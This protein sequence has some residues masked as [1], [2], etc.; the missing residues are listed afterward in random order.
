MN[1]N[2]PALPS[3]SD[4]H[5]LKLTPST[6]AQ[7][8]IFLIEETH[9]QANCWLSFSLEINGQLDVDKLSQALGH[10]GQQVPLLQTRLLYQDGVLWQQRTID[11][12]VTLELTDLRHHAAPEA[13]CQQQVAQNAPDN[14]CT[15]GAL[16]RFRLW[17]LGDE[18]YC[19][20][21]WFHHSLLDVRSWTILN[22]LLADS[23]NALLSGS[24]LPTFPWLNASSLAD[25]EQTW[26]TASTS[27]D[28][29]AFWQEYV[30]RLPAAAMTQ[31]II[32]EERRSLNVRHILHLQEEKRARILSLA[33]QQE[34]KEPVIYL[35]AVA[36][37]MRHLTG[38]ETV[39]LSLPVKGTWNAD[40]PGMTSNVVPLILDLPA[41]ATLQQ[42]LAMV[43]QELRLVLPHQRYRA[44]AI[45]RHAGL[46]ARQGF[47]PHV[48]IM[49]F[50]QGASFQNCQ[51]QAHFGRH[52]DSSDMHFTFWGDSRQGEVDILLDDAIEGHRPGELD[53]IGSQLR[54]FLEQLT[55]AADMPLY[56]LDELAGLHAHPQLAQSFYA[57][58][59]RPADAGVLRWDRPVNQ[60]ISQFYAGQWV[61]AGNSPLPVSKIWLDNTLVSFRKIDPLAKPD[62]AAPGTLLAVDSLGW[63]IAVAD[64]AV[65]IQGF[66]SLDGTPC[67]P[68]ALA[69]AS[70]ISPGSVLKIIS[71]NEARQLTQQWHSSVA[72]QGW[73]IERLK[74]RDGSW[75]SAARP[76]QPHIQPHWQTTEWAAVDTAREDALPALL[77]AWLIYIARDTGQTSPQIGVRLSSKAYPAPGALFASTLPFTVPV[78]LSLPFSHIA[79]TVGEEYSALLSHLPCPA[80][81]LQSNGENASAFTLCVVENAGMVDTDDSPGHLLTL[82]YNSQLNAI[83]W[84]YN[85]SFLDTEEAERLTPRLQ[86]LLSA[87][88][89]TDNADMP[90]AA[91][92]LLTASDSQLLESWNAPASAPLPAQYLAQMFE[93]QAARSA[94]AVALVSGGKQLTY[95]GLNQRANQLAHCLLA[96]GVS[97]EDRIAFCLER[98][99]DMVIAML[100]ILKAGAAYVALDPAYPSERLHYIL[101]DAAPACLLTDALGRQ[102][103]ATSSVTTLAL[104]EAL[105]R[106][107]SA[108]NPC[109]NHPALTPQSLAYI[110]YTSGSTG[111]PKGVMISHENMVNFLCWSQSVFSQPEMMRTFSATSLNFDLSVYEC[112]APL[113]RGAA[114]HIGENALALTANS[115][116][117]LL[118]TVPSAAQAL[119]NNR[120]FPEALASLNLAG[121][122]LSASLI[123]RIFAETHIQQLCNLYGPSETTTYSTWHRYTR[124]GAMSETIGRPIAN[125][126]IY[127]L[128]EAMQQVPPGSVGEIW[129]GGAGVARGY[130]NRQKL[131]AELLH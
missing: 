77:T 111:Q 3:T 128:D 82:Q 42:I 33:S 45:Q 30:S 90:A 44:Q 46:S 43:K 121:E 2:T 95:A 98:G 112:F 76:E 118:N 34:V 14:R 74:Q 107:Y 80:E 94:T 12:Q 65:H 27:K 71:E 103:M 88:A 83:R 124:D 108:D 17:Q 13:A 75:L 70:G 126:R 53:A 68:V 100:G 78:D 40:Q 96:R 48:N 109:L 59:R 127:L 92:P 73:W 87:A 81:W 9:Q 16:S 21:A 91:L 86:V 11:S 36:L 58:R 49:L 105:L 117:T 93:A 89:R 50:D 66:F 10:L 56:R 120:Q 18:R 20:V 63:H 31:R 113:I 5:N 104:D 19:L 1:A 125:T 39:S 37:L 35:S 62:D 38:Q 122:A 52:I 116:I 130:F 6:L 85:A 72:H 4:S 99:V 67:C 22:S 8:E 23:Y 61:G 25:E 97:P 110:I 7:E 115:D 54:F 29:A 26:L 69:Q 60:L 55:E 123:K 114:V 84:L 32:G 28:D 106:D 119:L 15:D 101:Q 79:D 51:T 131:T 47:G 41:H 24:S 102:T 57:L 64:G 129:I